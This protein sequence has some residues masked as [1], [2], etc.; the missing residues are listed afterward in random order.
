CSYP[1]D[2]AQP[3]RIES[4]LTGPPEPTNAPY[5]VAKL[6]GWQLCAAYHQQYGADF[7]TAIPASPFGPHDDFSHE[8]GHVIPALLR[9]AHEARVRDLPEFTVWGTGTPRREFL[10]SRDLA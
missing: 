3:L 6:A 4:L 2:A 10:Y 5:A 9:K 1:R 8:S 7:F